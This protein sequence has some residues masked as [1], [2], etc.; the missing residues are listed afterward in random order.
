VLTAAEATAGVA[1]F[2]GGLHDF[3]SEALGMACPAVPDFTRTDLEVIVTNSHGPGCARVRQVDD[4][5]FSGCLLD[6]FREA[7]A[8]RK[9]RAA[10]KTQQN[11]PH[12]PQPT[13]VLLSGHR[14]L[15]PA[16][17]SLP[18]TKTAILHAAPFSTALMAIEPL[19]RLRC[20]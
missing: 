12:A 10:L 14:P 5:A 6:V 19:I 9:Y 11:Q 7:A 15:C 2:P 17:P 8:L 20:R 16:D 18:P 1:R 4:G 13:A 3:A